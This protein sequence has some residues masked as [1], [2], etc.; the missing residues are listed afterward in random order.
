MKFLN[1]AAANMS[2]KAWIK[3]NKTSLSVYFDWSTLY[4]EMG[5][6]WLNL[7]F[8]PAWADNVSVPEMDKFLYNLNS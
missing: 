1:T 3:S 2:A 7:G 4:T 8:R 6:Q 5:T